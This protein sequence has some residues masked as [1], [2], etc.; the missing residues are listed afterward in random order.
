M[1]GHVLARGGGG[2]G[3]ALGVGVGQ[4]HAELSC[5]CAYLFYVQIFRC[6]FMY[7]CISVLFV[8]R[9]FLDSQKMWQLK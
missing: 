2:S 6:M 8:W 1:L 3:H 7:I 9:G 4:W 5:V